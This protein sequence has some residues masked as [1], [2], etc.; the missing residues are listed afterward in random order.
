MALWSTQPLKEMST[1]NLPGSKRRP[2]RKADNLAAICKPTVVGAST[3]HNPIGL[4]S[5]FLNG[6]STSQIRSSE[7][8]LLLV[9]ENSGV[10][11][12][13]GLMAQ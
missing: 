2:A 5:L 12:W 4:H 10:R 11:G 7:T 13:D 1:R 8:F 3:S 9:A 6:A